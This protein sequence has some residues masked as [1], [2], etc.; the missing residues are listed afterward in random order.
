MSLGSAPSTLHLL[1]KLLHV[2][3][4]L[5]G[6]VHASDHCICRFAEAVNRSTE[7]Y[8]NL[9]NNTRL[10]AHGFSPVGWVVSGL[11][12]MSNIF[13]GYGRMREEGPSATGPSG[14]LLRRAGNVYLDTHF[15][16]LTRILRA[17]VV[18]L[19]KTLQTTVR[20][21]KVMANLQTLQH[22]ALAT[23]GNRDIAGP[24]FNASR[25][26]IVN[27][28]QPYN[29]TYDVQVQE[30]PFVKSGT[31]GTPVLEQL[32]TTGVSAQSWSYSDDFRE[33]S[34]GAFT[35][36]S[37]GTL[38]LIPG[39]GCNMSRGDV[40]GGQQLQ[41]GG[42]ALIER[43]GCS[44]YTKCLLA[45]EAGAVGCLIFNCESGVGVCPSYDSSRPVVYGT[46]GPQ[47][48]E[49]GIPC[50]GISRELGL[51]LA[52][53]RGVQIHMAEHSRVQ[54]VGVANICASSRQGEANNTVLIGS[55]LDSVAA[56][57]GINDNGSGASAN[58]EIAISLAQLLARGDV[59]L[60][61]RL[62]FCWWGAE[63]EGLV[64]SR[65]YVS[66][67]SEA[68]VSTI[69]LNLNFDMIASPNYVIG[70]YN[71]SSLLPGGSATSLRVDGERG[72]AQAHGSAAL[73]RMFESKL[74]ALGS[75]HVPVAFNGRSDYGPFLERGIPAGGLETGAEKLKT[76]AERSLFG[77]M[78]HV[79]Y[80]PCYHQHCDTIENIS[81]AALAIN[82]P[83]MAWAAQ[84]LG[85]HADL[86]GFLGR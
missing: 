86:N 19:A 59:A 28:L 60:R 66:H 53:A 83:A 41:K 4:T 47:G 81:P 24:G 12:A 2:T 35:G 46:L 29:G 74:E 45:Q 10:D 32:S 39:Q 52:A 25:D 9:A 85:T 57:P 30:F 23:G 72:R 44:F 68:E 84:Y 13:T 1:C 80:D 7:V 22:I 58:L 62:R 6:V 16:L 64:G 42:I 69:A 34:N 51:T 70:V 15:P 21:E 63:E 37:N 5:L 43:G 75:A 79:A 49:L 31:V 14:S 55:H 71:G 3:C 18:T 50:F 65:W 82:V 20:L 77:G 17:R 27:S 40:A 8:L 26:F 36:S 56:G 61:N 67:L 76:E 48:L 38:Q 54:R 73:Q 11:D 78:P 33:M